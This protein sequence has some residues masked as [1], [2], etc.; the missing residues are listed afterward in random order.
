MPLYE[1]FCR[2]CDGVFEL[3]RPAREAPKAQPCPVCDEDSERVMSKQWAAFVFRD[4]YPRRIPD[5]GSHWHLGKKVSKPIS[6]AS[7]PYVH[8]ELKDKDS[9]PAPTVEDLERFEAM[10]E[11]RRTQSLEWGGGIDDKTQQGS[12]Q[13]MLKKIRRR[14]TPRVEQEKQRIM[15]KVATDE[16][17]TSYVT[18]RER[19][20]RIKRG[21]S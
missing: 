10:T 21:P 17:K 13:A 1:Y 9:T 16:V 8:P 20:A 14:G 19:D 6:E 5:D 12:E 4:G 2:D 15:R 11:A 18:R 3:L 7:Q